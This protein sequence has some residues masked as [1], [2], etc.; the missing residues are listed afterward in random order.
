MVLCSA[1]PY[2]NRYSAPDEVRGLITMVMR[3]DQYTA[4]MRSYLLEE[5]DDEAAE[6]T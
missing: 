1:D 5:D 4:E 6:G 2:Q 3:I